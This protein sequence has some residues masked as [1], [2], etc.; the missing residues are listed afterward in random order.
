MARIYLPAQSA[1]DWKRLL[2]DPELHWKTGYSARTLAHCWQQA[3]GWPHSVATAFAAA[4]LNLELLVGLPEHKVPL[5]GGS[6]PSQTDLF[7]L[8]RDTNAATLTAIAVEGKVSET[9]GPLI[10]EWRGEN[11]SGRGARLRHLCEVLGLA[12]GPALGAIRYQ[13]LHRTASAVIEAKRFDA[14]RAVMTVHSFSD[15]DAGLADYK[16]FAKL[17]GADDA[18]VGVV[19]KAREING[20]E[21]WLGWITGEPRFLDM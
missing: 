21:L 4:G 1:D 10:S 11:G 18:A 2:A 5:P 6:R 20:I 7:V 13:L 9:F 14:P 16:T 15:E 17:L 12:E 19:S 3:D 8:A